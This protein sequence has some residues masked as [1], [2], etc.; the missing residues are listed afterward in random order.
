[1][2]SQF[3]EHVAHRL[4]LDARVEQSLD[5]LELDEVGVGVETAAAT[6]LGIGD[7]RP[8]QIGAGPVV[9]L[10][11]GDADDLG[12]AGAAETA[13]YVH[14]AS[15]AMQV[16]AAELHACETTTVRHRFPSVNGR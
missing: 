13:P 15:P 7:R 4:E 10:P 14:V 16:T 2:R 3:V 8:D 1:M 12:G 11:I 6:P 5:Q 9:E